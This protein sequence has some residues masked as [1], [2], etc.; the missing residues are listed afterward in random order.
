MSFTYRSAPDAEQ[1]SRRPRRA[2]ALTVASLVLAI[3]AL[4]MA[5]AV[6]AQA[7]AFPA[8][9]TKAPC[10]VTAKTPDTVEGFHLWPFVLKKIR[11]AYEITCTEGGRHRPHR[12]TAEGGRPW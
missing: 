2:K 8:K 4:P 7:D 6:P 3:G 5:A 11:Y 10:T 1:G 12:A 9:A